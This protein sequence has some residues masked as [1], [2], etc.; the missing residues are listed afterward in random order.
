MIRVEDP[1]TTIKFIG[2]CLIVRQISSIGCIAVNPTKFRHATFREFFVPRAIACFMIASLAN[3]ISIIQVTQIGTFKSFS[4]NSNLIENRG[5]PAVDPKPSQSFTSHSPFP[6]S[7][8]WTI[9]KCHVENE[10]IMS[11]FWNAYPTTCRVNIAISIG[12]K[13]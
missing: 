6:S 9:R 8:V 7:S 4:R 5:K 11:D 13:T 10:I 3:V 12:D 2:K 1:S